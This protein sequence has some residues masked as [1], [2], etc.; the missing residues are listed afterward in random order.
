[1]WTY[2]QP[3]E[4]RFGAG[5]RKELPEL[6]ARFGARPILVTDSALRDTAMVRDALASL[7]PDA[8]LF[9]DVEP[10]PTVGSV[11]SA[12]REISG[13]RLRGRGCDGR[14]KLAGLREGR[15]GGRGAGRVGRETIIPRGQPM[16]AARLP[17]IAMPTTAG[18]GSEVT[19]IAVLDDPEKGMKA[20]MAHDSF[21]RRW[22]W[23][24]RSLR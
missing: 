10:N 19:P 12:V 18:T 21:S 13:E 22:R 5:S 4:I 24:I 17:L 9:S 20:P 8:R 6:V 3:T 1:M 11:D 16:G 23:S 2:R 15:G 7:G 14:R